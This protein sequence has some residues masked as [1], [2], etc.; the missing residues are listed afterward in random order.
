ML[1]QVED[2][3]S[4]VRKYVRKLVLSMGEVGFDPHVQLY[5]RT[6]EADLLYPK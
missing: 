1:P 4:G 6:H 2:T 5:R 3:R